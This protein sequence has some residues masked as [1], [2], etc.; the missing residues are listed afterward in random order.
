MVVDSLPFYAVLF[1]PQA[2]VETVKPQAAA[3]RDMAEK[4]TPEAWAAG[5]ARTMA[6]LVK[7]PVGLKSATE[8]SVASTPRSPAAPSMTT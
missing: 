1:S 6:R 5:Q 7:S 8:A 4:S 3:M 2:T